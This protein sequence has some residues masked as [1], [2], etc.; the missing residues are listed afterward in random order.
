MFPINLW[1]EVLQW[2]IQINYDV[3][4]DTFLLAINDIAFLSMPYQGDIIPNGP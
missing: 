2:K 4:N 3:P 1:V